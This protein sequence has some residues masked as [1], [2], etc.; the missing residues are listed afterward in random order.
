MIYVENK[1][2]VELEKYEGSFAQ[3]LGISEKDWHPRTHQELHELVGYK[4]TEWRLKMQ[5]EHIGNALWDE[6]GFESQWSEFDTE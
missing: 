4:G 2:V 6:A 1:K 3:E 5:N